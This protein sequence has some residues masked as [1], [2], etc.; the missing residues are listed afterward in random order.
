MEVTSV[1]RVIVQWLRDRGEFPIDNIADSHFLTM[2]K[3]LT[4]VSFVWL[5][6]PWPLKHFYP[7]HHK[8]INQVSFCVSS[9]SLKYRLS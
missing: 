9:M 2:Q 6:T 3:A 4:L 5:V 7:H 8:Q 1:V